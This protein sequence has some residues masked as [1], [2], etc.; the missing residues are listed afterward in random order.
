MTKD[1]LPLVELLQQAG[2]GDF[3]CGA[4]AVLQLLME[5]DVEG[6]RAVR[7]VQGCEA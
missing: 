3:L 1:R 4:A 2:D 6:R 5:A 7:P